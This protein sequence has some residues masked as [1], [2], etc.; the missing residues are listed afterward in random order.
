MLLA[1]VVEKK[2]TKT[3][4]A[5]SKSSNTV[6]PAKS[7]AEDKSIAKDK[8]KANDRSEEKATAQPGFVV[9]GTSYI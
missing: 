4:V 2:S 6:A 8:S 1:H 9:L 5:G 3:T 7:V